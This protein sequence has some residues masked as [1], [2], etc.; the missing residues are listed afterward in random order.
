M[1]DHQETLAT[2]A[3]VAVAI[4]GFTAIAAVFG[5]GMGELNHSYRL[6]LLILV[7][8]S[9]IVLFFS[10]LPKLI[11]E[12]SISTDMVWRVCCGLLGVT[13]LADVAWFLLSAKKTPITKGQQLLGFLAFGNWH[14]A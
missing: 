1:I 13:M 4:T 5:R 12:L 8:T 3:E 11:G 14:T 9:I 7:R 6:Q 10:F 2:F